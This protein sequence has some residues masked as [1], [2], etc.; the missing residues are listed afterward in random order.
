MIFVNDTNKIISL[1]K[2]LETWSKMFWGSFGL[3]VTI[4]KRVKTNLFSNKID[5]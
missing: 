3:K 2:L 4:P 5:E 1:L